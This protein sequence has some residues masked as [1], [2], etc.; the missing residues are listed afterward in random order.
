[1]KRGGPLKRKSG[2]KRGR[3][4]KRASDKKFS[5]LEIRRTMRVELTEE[6]GPLCEV[7]CS[8]NW[9]QMH[10]KL[11]RPHG[12][13]P[14]SKENQLCVCR[15]CHDRIHANPAWAYEMGYLIRSGSRD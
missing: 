12:G 8:A 3:G 14:T 10:D 4:P 7:C 15:W 6:R 1:M 11:R 2:L 9:D 5:E 13:D